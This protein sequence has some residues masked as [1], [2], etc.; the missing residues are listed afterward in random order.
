MKN[1]KTFKEAFGRN[2]WDPWSAKAGLAET[3]AAQLEK[4]LLSR[5][6]DPKYVTKDVKIAHSKSNEFKQWA[7]THREEV[8]IE[9]NLSE[10]ST[11][12]LHKYLMSRGINPLYVSKDTKIAHAKSNQFKQW[13]ATQREEVEEQ[14]TPTHQHQ[15][16]LK[17]KLHTRSA[18]IKTPRG[19]GTHSEEVQ[20]EDHVAIAMG[21]QLDDEGSMVL[22]QLDILDDAIAKLRTAIKDPKMQIPAWVQSKITLA[23]DYMDTVG[24]YMTSKNED[25]MNEAANPAQ[26]AAIA[27]NMKKK[28]IKPK[29]EEVEQIDELKTST[30]LRYATKAN[31]SLIGGDRSKEEKRIK[32]IQKANYKIQSRYKVKEEIELDEGSVQDTLHQ[33]QQALRK[34]SGLPHPDYYKEL[35]K[36][37]DIEDDKERLAKQSEIKKKYNVESVLYDNPKGTLT[38]VTE[39][40]KE[41]SRS[42]RIIKALY[43]K[44]GMKE[45]TYDWEKDDKSTA[46]YGKQPK[47]KKSDDKASKVKKESDAAAVLSGGTTMTKQKRD[48]VELDPRMKVRPNKDAQDADDNNRN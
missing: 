19:P 48:I 36:S 31:K 7:A 44:K 24:H 1:K 40:K 38:R 42:A 43:K 11:A 41:M 14:M 6:I 23:A 32:G 20:N 29:N 18:E 33:R 45:D 15:Q 46:S 16:A 2:P 12:Q 30:L 8:E 21:K 22:N 39:R 13:A 25:G 26:Q 34:K 27:I 28:G 47:F 37:Y 3:T 9:D 35:G 5:G 10:A 4:F 17:Q